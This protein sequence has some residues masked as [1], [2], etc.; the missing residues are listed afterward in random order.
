[1]PNQ[2][3]VD[4]VVVAEIAG[5]EVVGRVLESTTEAAYGPGPVEVHR[6]RV[7]NAGTFRVPDTR[8]S[9]PESA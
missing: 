2:D 1:M 8:V 4:D 7:P 6:V 3:V 9:T 5:R